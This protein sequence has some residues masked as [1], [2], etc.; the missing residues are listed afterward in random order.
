MSVLSQHFFERPVLTVA[1]ELLGKHLVREFPDGTTI[2]LQITEV[3]AYD[4]EKD[5][6]C[7]ASKGRTARTQTMYESGGIWYVYLVYGMYHMLNMVT[8]DADYPAAVLIRGAGELNGPGK[9]TKHLKVDKSLNARASATSTGLWIE[10]S[11][12]VVPEHHIIRTP[13][14][15]VDYAGEWAAKPY[16]FMLAS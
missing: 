12:V 3:E 6:A 1:P 2:K 14:I 11:G 4:G 15:G 10:E 9:L 13:R 7:H 5:L 8:G 16:R